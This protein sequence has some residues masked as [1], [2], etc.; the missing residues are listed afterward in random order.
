MSFS[1]KKKIPSENENCL[2]DKIFI[3]I[4]MNYLLEF[5]FDFYEIGE[6]RWL[7]TKLTWHALVRVILTSS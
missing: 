3:T 4:N 7:K 6:E 1:L 5:I 2:S